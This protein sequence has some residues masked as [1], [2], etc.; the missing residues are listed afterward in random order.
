MEGLTLF[1]GVRSAVSV[2]PSPPDGPT[3]LVFERVD[4][5]GS[6]RIPVR[7]QG[8]RE[9][10]RRTVLCLDAYDP[11]SPSVQT[12]EH[13]LSA[14]AGLGITDALIRVHGPELPIGD[15]SAA[16]F[17]DALLESGLVDL[18]RMVEPVVV[19][20]PVRVDGGPTTGNAV[21]IQ[22]E[23]LRPGDSVGLHVEY[24]LSY[25]GMPG[26]TPA[27]EPMLC[28]ARGFVADAWFDGAGEGAER[29]L[30][31]IAP[32]RTFS[33]AAEAQAAR[34]MGLFKHLSPKDMLVI[35]PD[36]PIDNVLRFP[37]EPI[38]H[39]LLDLIG[40][41]AAIGRPV[42]GRIIASRTGHAMNNRLARRLV[43]TA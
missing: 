1:T 26:V 19:R 4:L 17:V 35:G 37:D 3:G 10:M 33:L 41:V 6:P 32:A 28:G 14:L 20:E 5:P 15:G 39:K 30:R 9:E 24:R 18:D 27:V 11:A 29:Y 8:V 31:E 16:F 40:D 25:A 43:E 12:V 2:L 23:P 42:I 22:A 38:R 36:G 34:A 21:W 13:L 7:A